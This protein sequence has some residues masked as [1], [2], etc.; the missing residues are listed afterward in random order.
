VLAA[1]EALAVPPARC[2]LIGDTGGDVE[3]ALAA[4]AQAV[5]VPTTRTLPAEIH[6]A[7]AHARV[8]ETLS[9]AV[10]LVLRECR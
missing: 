7:R 9:D 3:A 8:A 10:S 4:D 6:H 2:V 5:L 1:A